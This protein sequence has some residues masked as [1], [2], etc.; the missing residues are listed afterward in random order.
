MRKAGIALSAFA[1]AL[2]LGACG[3]NGNN[4]TAST[5]TNN[6][7][8]ADAPAAAA[9]VADLAKS[10]SDQATEKTSAHMTM[11]GDFGGETIDGEGDVSF[12][13]AN[14]AMSMDLTTPEGNMSMVLVDNI[15]YIKMPEGQELEPGKPWLKID[16]NGD[17]PMAEVF[18]NLSDELSKNADPR[19]ALEQFKET[20]EITDTKEEELDGKQTTHYTIT[21]DVQKLADAQ[22]DPT[23]KAGLEAAIG[24]GLKDFPVE[25]WIDEDQLPVRI[26]FDMPAPDGQGGTASAK[27]QVDYTNWGEPVDI[28]APAA[29]QVTEFPTS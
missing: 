24:Q 26:A 16:P 3:D 9:N 4:N 19:S 20:G 15:V 10:I 14:P 28:A 11:T 13:A 27:M 6:G 12:D 5:G 17:N 8:G 21:V 18:G 1:L 22:E 29:D 25:V 23:Q 2:T 7:G